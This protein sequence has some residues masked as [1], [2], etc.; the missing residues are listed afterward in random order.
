[1]FSVVFRTV[2]IVNFAHINEQV[3][4]ISF[5]F[6]HVIVAARY[7]LRVVLS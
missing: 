3:S 2:V 6:C 4:I 1:M 7:L 5:V